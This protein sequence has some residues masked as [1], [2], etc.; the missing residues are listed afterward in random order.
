[1]SK[2]GQQHTKADSGGQRPAKSKVKTSGKAA[3][4]GSPSAKNSQ[5]QPGDKASPQERH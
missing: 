5:K 1:M 4:A 3:D 2:Q